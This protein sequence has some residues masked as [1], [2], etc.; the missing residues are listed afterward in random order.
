MS[1]LRSDALVIYGATGD[2]AFKKIF[3]ALQR[4]VRNGSLDVPIVGVA[5][6]GWSLER[7]RERAKDSIEKHG[8]GLDPVAFPRLMNLLRYIEGQYT[9]P[10]TFKTLRATLGN[11]EHPLHYMAVPQDL[12]ETVVNQLHGSRC[13]SGMRLVLE[14]PFGRDLASARQLNELLHG[15]LPESSIFRIDH[16]LGKDAVQNLVFFR[17]ANAFLEPIWNRRYVENVQ[18]T[19][20]ENF[21]I[22]GRG[23]FYDGTGAI[24]DVVQNH[25][26]QVLSNIA[27]EPPP[28][29]SDPET[30][31]EIG[32]A[33]V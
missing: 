27:M 23:A 26:L 29:S 4:M 19:M 22:K 2:L 8:G 7:L 25:L 1:P 9:D 33:H 32:R 28:V 31:R 30:L 18:I 13:D 15:C 20:A 16:Y 12:F 21:G 5:R 14:K 3:P 24:R 6:R 17:F 10:E 11:A